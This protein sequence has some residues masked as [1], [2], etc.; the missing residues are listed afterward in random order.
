MAMPGMAPPGGAP[1]M[2]AERIAALQG[3]IARIDA[4]KRG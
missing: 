4:H 2:G 1:K 3:I